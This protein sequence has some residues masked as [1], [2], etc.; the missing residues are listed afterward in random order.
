VTLVSAAPARGPEPSSDT[1]PRRSPLVIAAFVVVAVVGLA[2]YSWSRS[3]LWLDEALSVNIARLPLGQLQDALRHD[4]APP[5][6]YALLHV[7]TA[8]FGTS[9]IAVRSLSAVCMI[10]AVVAIWFV[11]RR[12]G[13]RQAA[14]ISV[15]LMASNPYAARYATEA[16]MYALEILLVACG[17]LAFQRALEAPTLSRLAVFGLVVALLAYTQYWTLYLLL[18]TAA[19]LIVLAVRGSHRDAARGMLVAMAV[20]GLTFLPWLS[21]FLYQRAHTGTPWGT[22]ILPGIPFGETLSD[23]AGGQEQEGWL[24]FFVLIAFLL[25]GVFGRGLDGRHVDVD[26]RGQPEVRGFAIF[27]VVTL[28]VALSLNYVANGAFQTRYGA[29][30]FAFFVVIVARGLTVLRD[31][32]VLIGALVVIVGLGF[33]GSFRNMATQRTQA[34]E[35]AAVLR[36]DAKPGDVVVYCPDQVG[37]AVHRLAPDGLDEVAYPNFSRPER[38]DWVDYKKRLAQANVPAFARAALQRVGEHTLWYVSAPG[39]IT[40]VGTCEALSA[41]FASA[42]SVH[43][44]T[45]PNPRI[46]EKPGLEEFPAPASGG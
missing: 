39:Y 30:V 40:H 24:L 37:P 42:R 44:R 8:V 20:A 16:R 5:L 9:D 34:G 41:S 1:S 3:D 18:V 26:L 23:F 21:T 25:L 19:L 12:V 43:V 4:G 45:S 7:W 46:F 17:I 32:R 11:A 10:G 33:V 36:R 35:V 28:L 13:G 31:P 2:C 6:Y 14:W 15:L 22:H 27:G 29:L 38:I